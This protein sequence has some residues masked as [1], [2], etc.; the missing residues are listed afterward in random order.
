MQHY[1]PRTS[2][3]RLDRRG[4]K[5]KQNIDNTFLLSTGGR[6]FSKS[7]AH[8]WYRSRRK[9]KYADKER[10]CL[11]MITEQSLHFRPESRV[12]FPVGIFERL[13]C[14][15]HGCRIGYPREFRGIP[16]GFP[17]DT[18]G[19]STEFPRHSQWQPMGRHTNPMRDHRRPMGDHWETH[20]GPIGDPWETVGRP[21]G[22]AWETHG[23]PKRGL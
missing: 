6:A 1:Q 17:W 14:P 21:V 22:G 4:K 12:V 9:N 7:G 8:S 15:F 18:R 3:T 10:L 2:T 11:N 5:G 19:S 16:T 23:R 20:G 13:S